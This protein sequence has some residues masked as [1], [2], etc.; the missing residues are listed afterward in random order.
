MN[1]KL[2]MFGGGSVGIEGIQCDRSTG[3]YPCCET[4][5]TRY[6]HHLLDPLYYQ[7]SSELFSVKRMSI[8]L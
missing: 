4:P 1:L 2:H 7:Q 6:P 5:L 8:L 3:F